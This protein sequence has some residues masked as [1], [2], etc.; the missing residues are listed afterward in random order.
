[1]EKTLARRTAIPKK[2]SM[3]I[4]KKRGDAAPGTAANASAA[5]AA[6]VQSL[7]HRGEPV[8]CD[9][10]RAVSRSA[11]STVKID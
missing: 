3:P 6:V 8:K 10:C 5:A 7:R 9:A 4:P 11:L 1:V 2:R